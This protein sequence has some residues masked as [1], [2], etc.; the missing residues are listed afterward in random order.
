[1][2]ASPEGNEAAYQDV[3]SSFSCEFR[4]GYS[5]HIHQPAE[6]VREEK[7]VRISSGRDRQWSKV[8]NADG[9]PGSIRQGY[10]ECKPADSLA[11]C[12]SRLTL[13]ATSYPPFYADFYTNPPVEA[14]QHLECACDTKVA[15]GIGMVCV[16]DP[17]SGQVRH[18]DANRFMKGGTASAAVVGLRRQ[19]VGNRFPNQ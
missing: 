2:W 9:H 12:F 11:R 17:R 8:V 14:F 3:G 4:G 19:G 7:D 16:H 10:G 6:T 15:R 1:M 13:E 18:V 5:E